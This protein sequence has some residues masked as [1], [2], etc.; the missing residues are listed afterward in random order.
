LANDVVL[1][2][3]FGGLV[4]HGRIEIWLFGLSQSGGG[5]PV[6]HVDLAGDGGGN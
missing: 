1:K 3:A 2:D 4:A 6:A 5:L